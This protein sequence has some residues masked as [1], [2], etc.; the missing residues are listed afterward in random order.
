MSLLLLSVENNSLDGIKGC[1]LGHLLLDCFCKA[2]LSLLIRPEAFALIFL[3]DLVG[4]LIWW[5]SSLVVESKE[6]RMVA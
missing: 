6:K 3:E 1:E 5:K 4:I 2:R